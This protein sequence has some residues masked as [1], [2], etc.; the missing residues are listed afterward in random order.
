MDGFKK[1]SGKITSATTNIPGYKS[2]DRSSSTPL[3]PVPGTPL[4][5]AIPFFP[6]NTPQTFYTPQV[7]Q[8]KPISAAFNS[9]GL[10][11]KKNKLTRNTPKPTPETPAK[12][13]NFM[14]F[15]SNS[16]RDE[17]QSPIPPQ[18]NK[19]HDLSSVPEINSPISKKVHLSTSPVKH[20]LD[21]NSF[22][23]P[24]KN[25]SATDNTF[26]TTPIKYSLN[27]PSSPTN[28][29]KFKVPLSKQQQQ[30]T[31]QK[32]QQHLSTPQLRPHTR[33][34]S[35]PETRTAGGLFSVDHL[36]IKNHL[37]PVKK[38]EIYSRFPTLT[39]QPCITTSVTYSTNN[40]AHTLYTP[41]PRFITPE[42]LEALRPSID[43]KSNPVMHYNTSEEI[44]ANYY[45]TR[46]HVVS[47]LGK[48]HYSEAFKV[49]DKQN[50]GYYAIKR[51]TKA[52]HGHN[53]R[54]EKLIE[55]EMM[56][57]IRGTLGCIKVETVWEQYGILYIQMELCDGG[58]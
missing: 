52:Y 16:P 46:F 10:I 11:S 22:Y 51:M 40:P 4:Q 29:H 36:T 41:Y 1:P 56:Y 14:K 38:F 15:N 37:S 47:T 45:S 13:L 3:L 57:A 7:K 34:F 2:I 23:T 9:T 24:T 53:D 31:P 48:G 21:S 20:Q 43:S 17:N 25:N 6:S 49:I 27:M 42:T 8:A 28:I 30:S 35:S 19:R 26:D 44:T 32:Q 39:T 50:G 5:S 58:T 18:F 12:K 54:I 33:R 55:V